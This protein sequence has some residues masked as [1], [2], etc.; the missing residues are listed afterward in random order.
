MFM[1]MS[2]DEFEDEEFREDA[3]REGMRRAKVTSGK[4]SMAIE[5]NDERV[6]P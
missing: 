6:A 5:V 3:M 2:E 1:T 4:G